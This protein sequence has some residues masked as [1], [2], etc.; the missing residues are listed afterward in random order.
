MAVTVEESVE[1]AAIENTIQ[2]MLVPHQ[3]DGRIRFAFFDFTQ[4][5][6]A[7]D[8]GSSAR[9]C[10]LPGGL[11]R[12]IL[13]LSRIYYSAFGASRVLDLGWESYTESDGTVIV[14]DPNGL[15]DNI[16]VSSAGAA[17]PAGTLGTHET[18]V[19]DSNDGVVLD[20]L[21]AGGTIPVGALL[22]G[23]YAYVRD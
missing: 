17:T 21:V 23:H 14:A 18:K 6:A 8:A 13:P 9:L 3:L 2:T 7:G 15:D 5:A 10:K 4:G 12:I 19:F 22:S 20:A 11:V 16:D 1:I